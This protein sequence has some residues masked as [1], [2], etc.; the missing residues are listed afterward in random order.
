MKAILFGSIGTLADTSE[1]QR[2][3]FNE[4]FAIHGLDWQWD[5]DQYITKLTESGGAQRIAGYAQAR[6]LDVDAA[7]IHATKSARFHD[8]LD[9]AVLGPRA[10]VVDTIGRARESGIAVALVT[11][12]SPGNVTAIL[13]AL[14][15]QVAR[16]DFDIITDATQVQRPK[17]AADAYTRTLA[18]LGHAPQDCV[19]IEDNPGGVTSAT[20]AGVACAVFPNA[21]TIGHDF[22]H[23]VV[24]DRIE[25]DELRALAAP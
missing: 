16:T 11:T 2:Q 13:N 4:A 20:A 23:A 15:P 5:R 24:I 3:A 25:V 17:P 8:L 12:T 1:L 9:K 19:A 6:D 22:G 21:N 10:G 18:E 7:A 14:G